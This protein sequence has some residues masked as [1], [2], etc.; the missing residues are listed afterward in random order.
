M[1][2]PLPDYSELNEFVLFVLSSFFQK[3][4]QGVKSVD[5]F[6]GNDQLWHKGFLAESY[7]SNG[8]VCRQPN[9]RIDQLG[10]LKINAGQK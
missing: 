3:R 1:K 10:K 6:A 5:F 9:Q 7:N 8:C 2:T 4:F